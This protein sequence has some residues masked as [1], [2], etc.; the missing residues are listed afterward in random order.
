[1]IDILSGGVL[2]VSRTNAYF[3]HTFSLLQIERLQMQDTP[4]PPKKKSGSKDTF[5]LLPIVEDLIPTSL[6]PRDLSKQRNIL[7]YIV[8]PMPHSSTTSPLFG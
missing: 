7:S 4:S 2:G 3:V 5:P 6:I 8:I 1:M